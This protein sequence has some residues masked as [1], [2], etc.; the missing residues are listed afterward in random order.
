MGISIS[1]MCSKSSIKKMKRKAFRDKKTEI[2]Y[3]Q[4]SGND[5]DDVYKDQDDAD[6]PGVFD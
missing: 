4:I 5:P 3:K 2:I 1:K 6:E